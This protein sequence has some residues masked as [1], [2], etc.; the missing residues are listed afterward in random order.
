[1][2]EG[3]SSTEPYLLKD[4]VCQVECIVVNEDE[5]AEE[6]IL[7][8]NLGYTSTSSQTDSQYFSAC[9]PHIPGVP[10]FY[11]GQPAPGTATTQCFIPHLADA[12]VG[13]D[14]PGTCSIQHQGTHP[15]A[16]PSTCV[17]ATP[18]ARH[19][20]DITAKT[21][22]LLEIKKGEYMCLLI[23]SVQIGNG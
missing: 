17:S 12:C 9:Q 20:G 5:D 15:P 7:F 10:I 19:C 8:I 3:L 6:D 23:Y 16:R 11:C 21:E 2:A 18:S 14:T 22:K 1:M 4:G 13:N